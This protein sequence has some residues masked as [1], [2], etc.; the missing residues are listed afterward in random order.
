[1]T[2]AAINPGQDLIFFD[3]FDTCRKYRTECIGML[4]PRISGLLLVSY[5]PLAVGVRDSLRFLSWCSIVDRR[6]NIHIPVI[7]SRHPVKIF[8]PSYYTFQAYLSIVTVKPVSHK[9][10]STRRLFVSP[11]SVAAF[12][13]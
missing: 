12:R 2:Y 8:F 10:A 13:A 9:E 7:L 11:G 3:C 5:A 1:M 4:K 6:L